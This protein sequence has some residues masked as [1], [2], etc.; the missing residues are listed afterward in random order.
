MIKLT[1]MTVKDSKFL[2]FHFK[3]LITTCATYCADYQDQFLAFLKHEK[4]SCYP[5]KVI[6]E[7]YHKIDIEFPIKKVNMS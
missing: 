3:C 4:I 2:L 7:G 1:Y 5:S 6:K